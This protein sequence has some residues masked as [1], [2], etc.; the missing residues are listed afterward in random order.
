MEL[1]WTVPECPLLE[2]NVTFNMSVSSCLWTVCPGHKYNLEGVGR[3]SFAKN[4]Q[5]K[6]E[7]GEVKAV[8]RGI[9]L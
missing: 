8:M 3:Q 6:W 2:S 4:W 5:V 7:L 1:K 9:F